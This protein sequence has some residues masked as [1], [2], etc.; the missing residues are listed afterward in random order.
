A[1]TS[2]AL[3]DTMDLCVGCKGCKRECPTGVDMAKM[4][5]E[6]LYHYRAQHGL[7]LRER[8][9]AYLPRYAHRLR[10]AAFLMNLRDRIPAMAKLSEKLLGLTAQRKLP[11]WRKDHFKPIVEDAVVAGGEKEVVLLVDTFNGCF[12]TENAIA[13]M[14][15]L[16]AAGYHVHCPLAEDHKRPLCCGRTFFS[17]GL[18]DEARVEAQRTLEALAPFVARGVPVVGLEPSCLL[19]LRDEYQALLPGEQADALSDN[20]FLFE[21]F[22][23]RE[24]QAARLPL[25]LKPLPQKQALV[26]GHCHQKAF[27]VMGSVHEV[28]ELIPELKVELIE[29]SCCGMAGSFGYEVEHYD[30]SMA[31]ANLSLIPAIA[32]ANAETLIVADGTSCRSQIQHGSGREALHVARVLQ[33]AL[34]VQ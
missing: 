1:F 8:L 14:A 3:Y 19:T 26:H 5:T 11:T 27:A 16:S 15:V 22:L 29:S 18:L 9:I 6:F 32:E 12:E 4:K 31:M 17:A 24:H 34:D 23:L 10:G 7:P 21:E 13:A 2:D 25:K 20:A 33:M 28:L 30:S